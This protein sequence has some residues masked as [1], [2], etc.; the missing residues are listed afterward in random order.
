MKKSIY[1]VLL[2]TGLITTMSTQVFA[3]TEPG[4]PML[5]STNT[6][7][8][9]IATT[10]MP[11]DSFNQVRYVEMVDIE[12]EAFTGVT[13]KEA[14]EVRY[15]GSEGSVV[16]KTIMVF[17]KAEYNS[18]TKVARPAPY[19]TIE[20]DCYVAMNGKN[21][22]SEG[23]NDYTKFEQILNA[24]NMNFTKIE[25]QIQNVNI[26]NQAF[27]PLFGAD[28]DPNFLDQFIYVEQLAVN[29]MTTLKF[30]MYA[31]S[32]ED[33]TEYSK[34]ATFSVDLLGDVD[35]TVPM[36]QDVALTP[37]FAFAQR[38]LLSSDQLK[39]QAKVDDGVLYLPVR[40][41]AN[42]T[43]YNVSYDKKTDSVTFKKGNNVFTTVYG[44]NKISKVENGKVVS[45]VETSDAFFKD[46]G[47]GYAPVSSFVEVLN[48]NRTLQ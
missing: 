31:P 23:T 18:N 39:E 3:D 11:N 15:L 47:V 45:S 38:V 5:I 20:N 24:D 16:V 30:D 19:L 7:T 13:P 17:D 4:T 42:L 28:L 26:V 22:Y 36:K 35:V 9:S 44:S 2:S 6:A 41:C 33:K 40:T 46:N 43:S 12:P 1:A 37:S 10:D 34:L 48:Y 21:P 32:N 27:K 8:D 25:N 14:Y 29:R